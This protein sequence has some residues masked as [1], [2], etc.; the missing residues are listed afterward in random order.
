MK[1]TLKERR[2]ALKDKIALFISLCAGWLGVVGILSA[3]GRLDSCF[4]NSSRDRD[5]YIFNFGCLI[6]GS[7][8]FGISSAMK[9][10]LNEKP[11]KGGGA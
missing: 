8:V 3:T 5:I 2:A 1:K 11:P 10:L 7:V 6:I 4:S 9:R